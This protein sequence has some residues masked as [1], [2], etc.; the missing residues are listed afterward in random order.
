MGGVIGE[1]GVAVWGGLDS[2][3]GVA[4]LWGGR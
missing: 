4:A 3:A 2:E 1:S